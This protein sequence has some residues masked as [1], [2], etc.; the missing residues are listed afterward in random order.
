MSTYYDIISK[1]KKEK[2]GTDEIYEIENGMLLE[3]FTSHRGT[4][5]SM[6]QCPTW[7]IACFMDD[8]IQSC[9]MDEETYHHMLVFPAMHTTPN[10]K[11]VMIIGGGEGATA[12]E[13]LRW[14]SVEHIDMY[15]WDKDVVHMF[16]SKY[17][18]WAQGAWDNPKLHLHFDNI[19]DIIST[20]P[21]KKYDIIIIDL[22]DPEESNRLQ[23]SYLFEYLPRWTAPNATIAMYA[24]MIVKDE[25][26]Q[27]YEMLSRMIL[28]Q[29]KNK[30][31]SPYMLPMK[32]FMGDAVFLMLHDA[33][34]KDMG[35]MYKPIYALNC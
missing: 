16:Q 4:H 27:P 29:L 2:D 14:P 3:S 23:W 20:E 18:Q 12:R 17:P 33:I 24:G 15:D 13:V 28:Q 1:H 8:S 5:V 35:A 31:I 26:I 9:E 32:S 25:P 19:F 21:D 11:R 30:D 10:K 22:F 6:I 7:G 34:V